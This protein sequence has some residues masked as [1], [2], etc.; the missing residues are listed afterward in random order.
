MGSVASLASLLCFLLCVFLSFLWGFQSMDLFRSCVV[1]HPFRPKVGSNPYPLLSIHSAKSSR[2]RTDLPLRPQLYGAYTGAQTAPVIWSINHKP[3]VIYWN[4][5]AFTWQ[6]TSKPWCQ[7]SIS[8]ST[9]KYAEFLVRLPAL[10]PIERPLVA[11]YTKAYYKI[12]FLEAVWLSTFCSLHI[13]RI[14]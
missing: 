8:Q 1:I 5:T 4:L 12:Q 9:L 6:D 11:Q 14:P 2:L 7:D 13:C 10:S 3:C